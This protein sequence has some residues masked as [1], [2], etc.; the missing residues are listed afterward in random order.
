MLQSGIGNA[1][2]F[3]ER[4]EIEKKLV[5]LNMEAIVKRE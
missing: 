3:S 2:P 5:K 4:D 1:S